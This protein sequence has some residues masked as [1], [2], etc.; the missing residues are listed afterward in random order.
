[1]GFIMIRQN[2]VWNLFI[3]FPS[4][5]DAKMGCWSPSGLKL[6]WEKNALFSE[7]SRLTAKITITPP[8]FNIAP[9]KWGLED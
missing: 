3:L 8:K 9:E 1:M 4:I 5:E 7:F 2:Y 6:I